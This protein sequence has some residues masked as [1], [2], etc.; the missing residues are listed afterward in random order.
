MSLDPHQ[1]L[2]ARDGVAPAG[3]RAPARDSVVVPLR[4]RRP[5]A[6]G[7]PV[8]TPRRPQPVANIA[9]YLGGP[10]RADAPTAPDA[11]DAL[12]AP[13]AAHADEIDRLL[14][15]HIETHLDLMKARAPEL[16]APVETLRRSVGLLLKLRRR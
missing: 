8:G 7:A 16:A 11:A 14:R 2:A 10:R 1:R 15:E 13:V 6:A 9:D 12:P 4:A 3:S 5:R